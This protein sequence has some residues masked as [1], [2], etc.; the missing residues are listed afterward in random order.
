MHDKV[1][2]GPADAAHHEFGVLP[3]LLWRFGA[4]LAADEWLLAYIGQDVGKRGRHA[5]V[6]LEHVFYFIHARAPMA[7]VT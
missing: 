5:G 7:Q 3:D 4:I 6:S 1:Q 2:L